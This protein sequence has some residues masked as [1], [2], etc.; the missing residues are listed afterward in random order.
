MAS[1]PEAHLVYRTGV[2]GRRQGGNQPN[3]FV[4]PKSTESAAPHFSSRGRSDAMQRRF[5]T[6]HHE[7]W[8]AAAASGP[9]DADH[10]FVWTWDAR[11]YPA[12]PVSRS[13]WSDGG[14]WRAGHWLNGRL[15]AT[16]LAEAIGAILT[17]HGIENFDTSEVTGDLTG[18][19]QAE[20]TSARSLLTPLL[21]VFRV[22]VVEDAGRLRFRSRGATSLEPRLVDVLADMEG[23]PLW[24]E[25]R[26]H[27][28]DFAAEVVLGSYNP[29][30]DYEQASVRSRRARTGSQRVL[31]YDLPAVLAEET[32]LAA[33]E[34][35]VRDLR[36]SRRSLTLAISPTEIDLQPGD[37]ISLP[38]VAGTFLINRI[39]DGSVRRIEAR[40][41]AVLAPPA[42]TGETGVP[43]NGGPAS[44][45]F[46][47]IVHFMDL[48]RFSAGGGESFA[49]AAVFCRP[50]QRILLSSSVTSEGYALRTSL[51]R[52]AR[53]GRLTSPLTKGVSGR[54]NR[55]TAI[56][57]DLFFGGLS[58]ATHAAVLAG[59][60]RLAIRA[61]NGAWEVLGFAEAEEI[62]PDRWRL[63]IL[64][65]GLAGTEDAM[66]AGAATGAP[67]V[68]LDEAVVALGLTVEERG[69]NLNW[70]AEGTSASGGRIG[71]FA[72]AGGTRAE[73][74][75]SPVHLRGL[76]RP[77]G[78]HLSWTRRSRIEADD[79]DAADI[80]LDEPEER[81]RLEI[82][83]GAEA[84]RTVDLAEPRH[85]YTEA[86]E[87]TDFGAPQPS[88]TIRVRQ[89]GR[90]VPLGLPAIATVST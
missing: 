60:N 1:G 38:G 89:L 53:T 46:A 44:N 83:D 70:V 47:P 66:M 4:D 45:A 37:P 16:T 48:P 82:L 68:L 19:V 86:Q 71:P 2:R 9:V 69:R 25:T 17:D 7:H 33:A 40:Q 10:V 11:P 78:W 57:L 28:S 49:R 74:P 63:S 12:F 88:L 36:V 29:A 76:R 31:A 77:D 72:F 51:D 56:E 39:D 59:E 35:A 87:L 75:L 90:A 21:D 42:P 54:F 13:I 55:G 6:A 52:P 80:P 43:G 24:S 58:S 15:G 79:W 20:V 61:A 41:H 14:N 73:T 81:Y 67:I 85:V 8:Q 84:K 18:Y 65:R 32:A 26:G 50:W 27:D 5:L 23:E 30:L 64:L 34:A 3:V 22:D 62:A